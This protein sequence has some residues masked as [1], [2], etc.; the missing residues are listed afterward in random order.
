ML[1]FSRL[2]PTKKNIKTKEDKTFINELT[3][4]II[5]EYKKQDLN[6]K[7][8]HLIIISLNITCTWHDIAGNLLIWC[9]T[10]YKCIYFPNVIDSWNLLDVDTQN[11]HSRLMYKNEIR[12][13][14]SV[15]PPYFTL[16]TRK[17]NIFH[18]QLRNLASNLNQH[19]FLSHLSDGSGRP[20]GDDVEDNFHFFFCLST[21]HLPKNFAV[22]STERFSRLPKHW[23]TLKG[24]IMYL[25]WTLSTLLFVEPKNL[26]IN[27]YIFQFDFVLFALN[28]F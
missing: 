24:M 16:G 8:I 6:G 10:S 20:C 9:S 17:Y 21:F 19:K 11:Q 22:Y 14:I 27:I 18:C 5:E 7:Y 15:T 28:L 13:N 3:S 12:S 25:L 4:K 1:P 2:L 26:T 23:C